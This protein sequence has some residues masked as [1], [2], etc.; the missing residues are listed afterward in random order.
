MNTITYEKYILELKLIPVILKSK[1]Q[2]FIQF[3]YIISVIICKLLTWY[4]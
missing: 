2:D 1:M 3:K 4:Y